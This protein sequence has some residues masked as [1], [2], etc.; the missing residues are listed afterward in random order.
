MSKGRGGFDIPILYP[1]AAHIFRGGGERKLYLKF[2]ANIA[3]MYMGDLGN[4]RQEPAHG[5]ADDSRREEED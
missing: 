5:F 2:K 3:V 1:S 4:G